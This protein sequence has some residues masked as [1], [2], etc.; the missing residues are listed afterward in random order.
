MDLIFSQFFNPLGGEVMWILASW[1]FHFI[2]MHEN[3][4][5]HPGNYISIGIELV[6]VSH[7]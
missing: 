4:A 2:K 1:K 6:K 3:L 5:Q 7:K